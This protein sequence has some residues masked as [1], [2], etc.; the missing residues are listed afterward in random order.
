[1]KLYFLLF[2]LALLKAPA[3]AAEPAQTENTTEQ[4]DE[5]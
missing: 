3:A 4:A 5:A 1:M 2:F